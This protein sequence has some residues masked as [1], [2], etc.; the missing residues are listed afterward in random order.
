M[1]GGVRVA[2][3]GVGRMGGAMAGTLRRAGF[4]VT[5]WNRTRSA[6]EAVAKLVGA[7]LA[8]GPREAA[9]GADV[10]ISSLADDAAVKAVY[11]GADGAAAG[12]REGTVVLETST[13]AP[14]TVHEIR[15][16]IEG[17]GA[18]LLDAPVSG[19]VSLVT[20]GELTVMVGGDPAALE[21]ARPV[22]EALAAKL[23]HVGELGAGATMKLAVNALVHAINVALSEALVLAEKAGVDRGRAYDVFAAGAGAAPFVLYKRAAFERPEETPVAFSLD[24]V[25]KD[26]D[27]ILGLADQV[28]ARMDQGAVNRATARA[29]I[30][31]GLGRRDMS[32]IATF[33]RT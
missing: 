28:G 29:A 26:L 10:V 7:G 25:A 15:P 21:R 5:L 11:A 17:R 12:L 1:G 8:A 31:A 13:I 16:A 24:L 9:A 30:A 22:L 19:S 27:L 33:L 3:L 14:R 2:I 4:D 18:A 23:F 20:K 6:A 32:S